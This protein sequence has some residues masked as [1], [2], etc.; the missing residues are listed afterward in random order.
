L[1]FITKIHN[2]AHKGSCILESIYIYAYKRPSTYIHACSKSNINI[3]LW[4]NSIS[5]YGSKN[6]SEICINHLLLFCLSHLTL[7]ISFFYH[8]NSC[9]KDHLHLT[10]TIGFRSLFTQPFFQI[11][12]LV[13]VY[14]IH[15]LLHNGCNNF[16]KNIVK[17]IMYINY[18]KNVVLLWCKEH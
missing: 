4:R 13:N 14:D 6:S 2:F 15:N 11:K 16:T 3:C 8:L 12:F 7:L 5:I 18:T 1:Q 17:Q 9:L 10:K